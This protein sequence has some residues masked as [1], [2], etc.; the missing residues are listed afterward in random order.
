MAPLETIQAEVQQMKKYLKDTPAM[1][2]SRGVFL[3]GERSASTRQQRLAQGIPVDPA[4]WAQVEALFD[5]Y[6]VRGELADL[7]PAA[8][9][10]WDRHEELAGALGDD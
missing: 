3:P 1:E 8:R 5:P 2:G 6:G 10:P 7:L 9:R 4:T